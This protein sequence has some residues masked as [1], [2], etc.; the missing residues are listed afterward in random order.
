[1][2]TES[3]TVARRQLRQAIRRAREARSLTQGQIAEALEWSLSKVNRIESG[4]VTISNTDLR[5]LLTL[6]EIRDPAE[7]G[8]LVETGRVARR[9]EESDPFLTP[10]M[11][12]LFEYEQ[13]GL[14]IRVFQ[15]SVIP[16][17]LQTA[18]YA[19]AVLLGW[20]DVLAETEVAARLQVRAE[21]RRRVLDRDPPPQ[22]R[23]VLDY[24]V[25]QGVVG[26]RQTMAEQLEALAADARRPA[27]EVRIL[28]STSDPVLRMIGAYT[29]VDLPGGDSV[30]YTEAPRHDRLLDDPQ[31]MAYHGSHFDRAWA[32]ALGGDESIEFIDTAAMNV[33]EA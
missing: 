13:D 2:V 20:K 24:S 10:A 6:L 5:A 1:M 26:S 15:P 8:T 21:R 16:G 14:T 12:Q 7:V 22:F 23:V 4:D 9:R 32:S 31:E 19:K 25:T 27:I 17:M 33:S 3:P 30:L 28:P 29:I 11:R 18:D